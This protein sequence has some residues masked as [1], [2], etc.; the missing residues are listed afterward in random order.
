MNYTATTVDGQHIQTRSIRYN[1]LPP[2]FHVNLRDALA[3]MDERNGKIPSIM[4]ANTGADTLRFG[5][6]LHSVCVCAAGFEY[7]FHLP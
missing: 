7:L 3:A 4:F 6:V 1:S 5:G 2:K